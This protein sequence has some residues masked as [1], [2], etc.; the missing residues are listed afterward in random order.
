M[1]AR[2]YYQAFQSVTESIKAILRGENAGTLA[3]KDHSK[4]YR[5]SLIQV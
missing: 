1:A 5:N 3:D 4:W 2:G